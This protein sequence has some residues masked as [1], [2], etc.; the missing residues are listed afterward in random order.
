M[1]MNKN[2]VNIEYFNWMLSIV[3]DDLYSGK[4]SFRKLLRYL[5]DIE[6]T[7]IVTGDRNRAKDG[8]D[9]R[10]RFSKE[11][12]Y[13]YDYLAEYL[14]GPC[15]VLEMM[16]ALAIR[17]EETIMDDPSKGDRTRQWFWGMINNLGLGAMTDNSFD[18]LQVKKIIDIFL[19]REYER[20]GYG[21]LFTVRHC[22]R[23]LRKIEIWRQLCWYLDTIS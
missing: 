23:D 10:R 1:K 20:N 17:C 12:G 8:V 22:T 4:I 14:E 6:F 21:G 16:L 2:E 7:W 18:R 5:H 19:N 11:S 3:H 13:E 9:L 15:S